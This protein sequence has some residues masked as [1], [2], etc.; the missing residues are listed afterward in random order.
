M[1]AVLS[2]GSGAL[3]SHRAAAALWGLL[4]GVPWWIDVLTLRTPVGRAARPG[5]RGHRVRA[6]P[7][8]DRAVVD[9]IPVTSVPRTLLD[10]S[11]EC[12]GRMLDRMLRRSEELGLFDRFALAQVLDRP[13]PGVAKLRASVAMFADEADAGVRT[14]SELE[15][16]FL[17]LLSRN[18]FVMPSVNV[19]VQTPWASYEVDTLW[20]ERRL[21][22]E[23]DGW[24]AHRDR[25]A[26]RRD[27]R[28][29]ADIPAAGFEMVRL[30]W[31]QVVEHP[32]ETVARLDRLVPRV[33]A[34]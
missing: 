25:E 4:S 11:P 8:V 6:I 16:R 32:T 26:F 30:D 20:P 34:R 21:V 31:E 18:G 2:G 17:D 19:V 10:L 22:I 13:R 24:S 5:V 27:H 29:A 7:D 12:D 33:A 3:L 15:R 9:G 23:V 1:A 14:K 28:R